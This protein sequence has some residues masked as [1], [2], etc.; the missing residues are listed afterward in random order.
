MCLTY[1]VISKSLLDSGLKLHFRQ[2]KQR[3][4]TSKSGHLDS[5]EIYSAKM[6]QH[7]LSIAV[8]FFLNSHYPGLTCPSGRIVPF[9]RRELWALWKPRT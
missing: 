8:L 4:E 7:F 5:W 6:L 1:T 9:S 3:Q 2:F